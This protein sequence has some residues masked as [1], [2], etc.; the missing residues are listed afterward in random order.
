M[1]DLQEAEDRVRGALD[2]VLAGKVDVSGLSASDNLFDAGMTSHQTVQVMLEL[3]DEFDVEFP[4]D[5]LNKA[6]FSSI[7]SMVE[8]LKDLA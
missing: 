2:T 6:T 3:E 5:R 1:N 7:G 8:A 4:D